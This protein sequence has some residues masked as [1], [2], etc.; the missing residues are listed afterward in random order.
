LGPAPR[1][2]R[3]RAQERECGLMERQFELYKERLVWAD[4]GKDK[5]TARL[6]SQEQEEK[7]TRGFWSRFIS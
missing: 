6:T 7:S 5:L 4:K 2:A 3:R 1:Y